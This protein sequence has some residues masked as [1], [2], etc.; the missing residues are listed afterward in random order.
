MYFQRARGLAKV[1]SLPIFYQT[2]MTSY[3]KNYSME[4]PA[5]AN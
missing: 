3:P 2:N 5:E 4:I 1:R